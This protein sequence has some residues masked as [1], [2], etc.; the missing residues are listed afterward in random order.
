M[1]DSLM[2]GKRDFIAPVS[3]SFIEG[4]SRRLPVCGNSASG[5]IFLHLR[6]PAEYKKS[7][8]WDDLP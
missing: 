1:P 2:S 5:R 8:V 6:H 7:L 3:E 4:H